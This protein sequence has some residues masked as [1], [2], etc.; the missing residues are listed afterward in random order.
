MD[1]LFAKPPINCTNSSYFYL[2]QDL[3]PIILIL[4]TAQTIVT[5]NELLILPEDRF[6][7]KPNQCIFFSDCRKRSI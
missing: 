5:N 6:G 3:F 7:T 2:L 1:I 4:A